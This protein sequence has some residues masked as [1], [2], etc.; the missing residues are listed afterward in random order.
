[1]VKMECLILY[2]QVFY[3][4]SKAPLFVKVENVEFTLNSH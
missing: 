2:A 3:S 4:V 1:M